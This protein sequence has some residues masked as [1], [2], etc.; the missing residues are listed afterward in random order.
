MRPDRCEAELLR[1]LAAMPFLDRLEMVEVSGWSRGAVYGAVE[2]LETN[3]FCASALH[4]ADPLPPT[5]RCS[6]S[7]PPGC[8]VSR[9]RKACPLKS[10]CANIPSRPSGGAA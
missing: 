1:A 6:T 5:R 3:G 8:A 4:A 2:K 10:W 9:K 7:P